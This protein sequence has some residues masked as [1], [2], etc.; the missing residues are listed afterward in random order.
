MSGSCRH[1]LHIVSPDHCLSFVA[2]VVL[3][4]GRPGLSALLLVYDDLM[5]IF[6]GYCSVDIISLDVCI[7][8]HTSVKIYIYT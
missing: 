8:A 7:I 5:L 2:C 3:E 4:P 6:T 1:N